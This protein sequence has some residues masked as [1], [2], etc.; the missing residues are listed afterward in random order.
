MLNILKEK[1]IITYLLVLNVLIV[2]YELVTLNE[3]FFIAVGFFSLF[4]LKSSVFSNLLKDFYKEEKERTFRLFYD[5]ITRSST[6]LLSFAEYFSMYENFREFYNRSFLLNI[7]YVLSKFNNFYE[8]MEGNEQEL[9]EV[10]IT[11]YDRLL[12]SIVTRMEQNYVGY[13]SEK[14]KLVD[15]IYENLINQ[16]EV[17]ESNWI[18]NY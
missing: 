6:F 10:I 15:N 2:N 14:A 11:F 3:E 9:P 5:Q 13:F 8:R 1:K 7:E 4:F 12:S 17:S 16:Q 18:L